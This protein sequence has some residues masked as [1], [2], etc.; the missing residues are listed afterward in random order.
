MFEYYFLIIPVITLI[1][2]IMPISVRLRYSRHASNDHFMVYYRPFHYIPMFKLELPIIQLR[3]QGLEPY[4]KIFGELEGINQK[5]VVKSEVKVTKPPWYKLPKI[6]NLTPEYLV[7]GA[8]LVTINRNLLSRVGCLKLQWDTEF[9]FKDASITGITAGTLWA[10][11][12]LLVQQISRSIK[13]GHQVIKL[14]VTP[15]YDKPGLRIEFD[16]ILRV[17]LG[18]III[19]GVRVLKLIVSLIITSQTKGVSVWQRITQLNH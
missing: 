4:L 2:I 13:M 5:P 3:F 12:S 16:C 14:N 19:A 9:G 6:L 11:K 18:Y 17:R 10:G 8:K 1:A 7:A 15:N